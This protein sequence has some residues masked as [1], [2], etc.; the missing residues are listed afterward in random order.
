MIVITGTGRAGTTFLVSLFTLLGFDTG[1]TKEQVIQMNSGWKPDFGPRAGLEREWQLGLDVVKSPSFC[2]CIDAILEKVKVDCVLVPIR[3]LTKAAQS[4]VVNQERA[5]TS[6][7][8]TGGFIKGAKDLESQKQVLLE[9]IYKLCLSSSPF[10]VP[11]IFLK[12]PKLIVDPDYLYTKLVDCTHI[13]V[14]RNTF[15]KSFSVL[16]RP[17]LVEAWK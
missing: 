14:D 9:M 4:R 1:F 11:L 2:Y 7:P 12:Y 15:Y 8:V 13:K 16:S 6:T 10:L 5:K 3:D 17:E